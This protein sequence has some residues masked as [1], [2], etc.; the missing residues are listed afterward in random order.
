MC[1]KKFCPTTILFFIKNSYLSKNNINL[2]CLF[3][4]LFHLYKVA[5]SFRDVSSMD[6]LTRADSIVLAR[7][8]SQLELLIITKVNSVVSPI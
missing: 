1:E 3:T 5:I 8:S 2:F 6:F 4:S 7:V